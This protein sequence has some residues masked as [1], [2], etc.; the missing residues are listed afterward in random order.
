M[1]YYFFSLLD[2]HPSAISQLEKISVSPQ[3]PGVWRDN[4]NRLRI[5]STRKNRNFNYVRY[6]FDE[7]SSKTLLNLSPFQ[8]PSSQQ[9]NQSNW[10]T[11]RDGVIRSRFLSS[12]L[13]AFRTIARFRT[14]PRPTL[15]NPFVR[16]G[17]RFPTLLS[18][19][20]PFTVIP[21]SFPTFRR[22]R[23]SLE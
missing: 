10:R 3:V 7:H 19:P 15:L 13:H 16:N 23:T 9:M 2:M 8:H 17:G 20:T 14:K 5:V 22:R 12:L 21:N 1:L 11:H 18:P 6:R 4:L